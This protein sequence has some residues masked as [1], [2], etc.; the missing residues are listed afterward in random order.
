MLEER[1]KLSPT[2][3]K[4]EHLLM[5]RSVFVC[6]DGEVSIRCGFGVCDRNVKE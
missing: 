4:C 3:I 2:L 1:K 6:V 5:A